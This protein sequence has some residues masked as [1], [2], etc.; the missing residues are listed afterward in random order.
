MKERGIK[1]RKGY[2]NMMWVV[3]KGDYIKGSFHSKE[4]AIKYMIDL[5]FDGYEG[6]KVKQVSKKE[7]KDML[8]LT[9]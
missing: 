8:N 1:M 9:K 6:W 7:L 5:W 4:K 3:Y 2:K